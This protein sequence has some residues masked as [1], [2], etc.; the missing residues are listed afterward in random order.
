MPRKESIA[1]H[2]NLP[3]D[4]YSLKQ[5][6]QLPCRINPLRAIVVVGKDEDRLSQLTQ[7]L[8]LRRPLG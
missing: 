7:F 5:Q 1:R 2:F 8:N 6:P 4:A 3:D